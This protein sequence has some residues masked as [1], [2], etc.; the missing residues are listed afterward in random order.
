LEIVLITR[1]P[2]PNWK[3]HSAIGRRRSSNNVNN[4]SVAFSH[5][6]A[7]KYSVVSWSKKLIIYPFRSERTSSH[8]DSTCSVRVLWNWKLS[9]WHRII[10]AIVINPE[11]LVYL[12]RQQ[13]VFSVMYHTGFTKVLCTFKMP[14]GTVLHTSM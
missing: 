3:G 11:E 6:I 5:L 2:K 1:K 8:M 9:K 7:G 14:Y 10:L 4:N 13:M 12:T